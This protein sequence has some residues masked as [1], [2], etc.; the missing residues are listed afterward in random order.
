MCPTSEKYCLDMSNQL[1]NGGSN[2]SMF[3]VIFFTLLM[4]F[5]FSFM[6][7]IRIQPHFVDVNR[8]RGMGFS[9]GALASECQMSIRLVSLAS[10][11]KKKKWNSLILHK[12]RHLELTY[13]IL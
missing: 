6:C 8:G 2:S 10:G 3:T 11:H 13:N 9:K 12:I 7:H 4:F 5:F 1:Q